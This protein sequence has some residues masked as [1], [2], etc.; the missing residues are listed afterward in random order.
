MC[1]VPSFGLTGKPVG[2]F[3][4]ASVNWQS[5]PR[6][7]PSVRAL[8]LTDWTSVSSVVVHRAS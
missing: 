7:Q 8:A 4:P 6:H 2:R 5:G 3:C 1:V